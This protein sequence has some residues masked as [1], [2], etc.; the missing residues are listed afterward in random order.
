MGLSLTLVI[1]KVITYGVICGNTN[2]ENEG[3]RRLLIGRA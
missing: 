3:V 1:G 2:L